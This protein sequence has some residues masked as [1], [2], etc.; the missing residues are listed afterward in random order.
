MAGTNLYGDFYISLD[1]DKTQIKAGEGIN[2]TLKITGSGNF[3]D[4]EAYKLDMKDVN[5]YS[6]KPVVKSRATI[7]NMQGEFVQKFSISSNQDFTIPSFNITYYDANKKVLVT[8]KTEPKTIY[9]KS[10]QKE[11]AVQVTSRKNTDVVVQTKSNYLYI[12][13]SFL[14]GVLLTLVSI[15]IMKRKDC[16]LPRFKND[17]DHLKSLL[18]RRGESEEIDNQ[19]IDLENRLYKKSL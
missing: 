16:K 2:V 9:V 12:L 1:T 18:K 8:K 19:I 11:K 15:F 6:D 4:I 13:L 7:E 14:A 17:R 3:D 10:I 5:I